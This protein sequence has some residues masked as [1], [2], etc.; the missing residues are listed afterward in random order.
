MI[1]LLQRPTCV[2]EVIRVLR[3]RVRL[4]CVWVLLATRWKRLWQLLK[5][6]RTTWVTLVVGYRRGTARFSWEPWKF[7]S[8]Y[9]IACR[10]SAPPVVNRPCGPWPLLIGCLVI[11][12]FPQRKE[13]FA[14]VADTACPPLSV[15]TRGVSPSP[16]CA[17]VLA[18][19]IT[20]MVPPCAL[21]VVVGPSATSGST[22]TSRDPKGKSKIATSSGA[23]NSGPLV[24]SHL[25][26]V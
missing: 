15:V 19:G 2:V 13:R 7:E 6:L 18:T 4:K 5:L 9:R 24:I 3:Y 14:S 21:T 12:V 16:T 1:P 26:V 8:S 10:R 23:T 25:A 11:S 22:C 20:F 17:T